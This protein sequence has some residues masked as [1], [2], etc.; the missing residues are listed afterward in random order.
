ML[1]RL[2]LTQKNW[3]LGLLLLVSACGPGLTLALPSSDAQKVC[4]AV[5][6]CAQDGDYG[7]LTTCNANAQ[8]LEQQATASG[9]ASVYDGY[10]SCA[11]ASYTC[12]GVTPTFPGCDTER[13]ALES[14][15]NAAPQQSACTAYEA[16]LS[17]CP[18]DAGSSSGSSP[19]IT[20]CT[21]NLQCQARCYLTSVSNGC[22]PS[23]GELDAFTA[24]AQSCP[25]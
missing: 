10:Y 15:L 22:A 6:D 1:R 21:L 8:A 18:A 12:T 13:A 17:N 9:C 3:T 23:L 14:C 5:D 24:C 4:E 7:W 20:A 19:I 16:E 25:P 11:N 2:Q